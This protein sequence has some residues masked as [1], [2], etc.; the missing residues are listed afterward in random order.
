MK[1]TARTATALAAALVLVGIGGGTAGAAA[2]PGAAAPFEGR[3]P[4][5]IEGPPVSLGTEIKGLS[6]DDLVAGEY[7]TE[8]RF[9]YPVHAWVWREGELTEIG[10]FDDRGSSRVTG[11]A[12]RGKVL[13]T[14][15]VPEG[16][17]V[18]FLWENGDL[19]ALGTPQDDFR[20][21]DADDAGRVL[22]TRTTAG[23]WRAS[24]WQDGAFRTLPAPSE[25]TSTWATASNER[26]TAV[27]TCYVGTERRYELLWQDGGRRV[28]ALAPSMQVLDVDEHG[29]LAGQHLG[30]QRATVWAPR[31]RGGWRAVDLGAAPGASA[32]DF[33]RPGEV[34]VTEP[35]APGG[36]TR[37]VLW[38]GGKRTALTG[39]GQD[40]EAR[41]ANR[42]GHVLGVSYGNPAL[43]WR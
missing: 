7:V 19:R 28:R 39:A 41:Q 25:C 21:V 35:V 22:G 15:D 29:W 24:I 9:T 38:G 14:S 12:G 4:V 43:L 27:G 11:V 13:G 18:G 10:P 17:Q 37:V 40:Y 30:T 23:T 5:Q 26:G 34:V 32:E 31:G 8:G 36:V 42:H 2:P 20:P 3:P 16:G 33:G 6:D 1:R